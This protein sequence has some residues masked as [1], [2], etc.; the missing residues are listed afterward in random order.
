MLSHSRRALAVPAHAGAS[1]GCVRFASAITVD[2]K[3]AMVV[4]NDPVRGDTCQ[5]L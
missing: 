3:G 4:P 1:R 2:A 5:S